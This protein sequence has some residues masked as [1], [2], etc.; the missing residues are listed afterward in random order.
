MSVISLR[1]PDS[2]HKQLREAAKK[3]GVSINQIAASALSEKLAAWATR[4]YLKERAARGSREKFDAVLAKVPSTP[5]DPR[6][7]TV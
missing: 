2:L 5:P 6:D 3:E 4:D 7:T 1:L